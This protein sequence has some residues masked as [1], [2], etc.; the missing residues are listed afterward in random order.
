SALAEPFRVAYPLCDLHLHDLRLSPMHQ[1]HGLHLLSL[2]MLRVSQKRQT[3]ET[4]QAIIIA[5]TDWS[6]DDLDK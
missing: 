6:G 1:I 4:V 3:V 2:V 5:R